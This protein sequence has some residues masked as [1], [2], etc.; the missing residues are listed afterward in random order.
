MVKQAT[1]QIIW[2]G[3]IGTASDTRTGLVGVS[4]TLHAFWISKIAR[5]EVLPPR[6]RGPLPNFSPRNNQSRETR[7]NVL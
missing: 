7:Q 3:S 2:A 1:I 6:T 5:R 4:P